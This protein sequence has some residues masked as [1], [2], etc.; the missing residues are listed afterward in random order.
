MV[1]SLF[2][3][4]WRRIRSWRKLPDRRDW[5]RGKLGLVLMGG[6][7]LSKSLVQ[8]SVDGWGCVASLLLN[9][10]QTMV[11]IMK[12]MVTSFKRSHAC[13]ATL[14]PNPA[15]R[16]RPTPLLE[17]PGHSQANLGQSLVGSLLLS[18]GSWYAQ[19]SSV[20]AVQESV[21]PVLCRFW[22][23]YGG[24]NGDLLQGGLCHIQVWCTQSPYHWGSP[25]LT[26]TSTGD[27][28]TQFCLSL[29]GTEY[30]LWNAKLEWRTSWN[31]DCR[32][33]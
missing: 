13:T 14:C 10:G 32:E 19:G 7:L 28:Q 9:W 2:A 31:Q 4:W 8:F 29:C 24:V 15:G 30:I 12:I 11:G 27:S 22:W 6:A 21:S 3:L 5:L 23:L 26:R 16:H 17:T 20:C 25:L 33:K 1:F 18:S